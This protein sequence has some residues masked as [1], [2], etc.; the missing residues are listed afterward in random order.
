MAGSTETSGDESALIQPGSGANQQ[1]PY[2]IAPHSRGSG[3]PNSAPTCTVEAEPA[4]ET[5]TLL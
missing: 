3:Q 2:P 4:N 1:H 5:F